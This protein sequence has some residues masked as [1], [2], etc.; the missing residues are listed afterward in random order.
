MSFNI[1][2][3]YNLRVN[4]LCE[5]TSS[6]R[7]VIDNFVK[8]CSFDFFALQIG[9]G[10]HEVESD[11]TLSQFTDEQLLLLWRRYIWNKCQTINQLC[12]ETSQTTLEIFPSWKKGKAAKTRETSV[13]LFSYSAAHSY[14]SDFFGTGNLSKKIA[15]SKYFDDFWWLWVLSEASKPLGGLAVGGLSQRVVLNSNFEL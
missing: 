6:R 2:H 10:V 13:F 15:K 1:Y 9:H 12:L 7:D 4:S 11:A 3:A 8:C 5:D 14:T